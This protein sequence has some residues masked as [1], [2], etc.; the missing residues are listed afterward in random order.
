VNLATAGRGLLHEGLAAG[1][2][3]ADIA[4]R[5]EQELIARLRNDGEVLERSLA[6]WLSGPALA[7]VRDAAALAKLPDAERESWQRFWTDVAAS[8]AADPLEQGR[9]RAGQR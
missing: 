8:I 5:I 1:L 7:T 9:E 2:V 3:S 6:T 4:S